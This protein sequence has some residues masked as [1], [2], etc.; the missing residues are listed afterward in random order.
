GTVPRHASDRLSQAAAC[1]PCDR[2]RRCRRYKLLP[3]GGSDWSHR[4]GQRVGISALQ[5]TDA[6][7][8]FAV[9]VIKI[10]AS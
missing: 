6:P 5:G 1:L 2:R 8:A 4:H 3:C 10:D 7:E 9:A